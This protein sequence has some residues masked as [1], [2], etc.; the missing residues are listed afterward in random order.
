M[1]ADAC[2]TD[3]RFES[4]LFKHVLEKIEDRRIVAQSADP[5][6]EGKQSQHPPHPTLPAR[7]M[8][9]KKTFGFSPHGR[10]RDAAQNRRSA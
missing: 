10:V 4:A 1:Q 9:P 3:D 7:G 2:G 8:K 6:G 5:L